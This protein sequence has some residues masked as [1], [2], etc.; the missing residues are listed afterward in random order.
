MTCQ[1]ASIHQNQELFRE[2]DI[3]Q[4]SMP[5]IIGDIR[6]EDVKF[7]FSEKGPFQVDKVN[8]TIQAGNFVGVVG[9]SGSGKSTLMKLLPRLYDPTKG[10]ILIDDYDPYKMAEI[11]I[12]ITEI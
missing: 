4:I 2:D 11:I 6:F 12:D 8:L 9:Q 10:R 5:S 3:D 7:R 1:S